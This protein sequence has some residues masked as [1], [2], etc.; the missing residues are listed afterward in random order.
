MGKGY[1]VK[2]GIMASKGQF[3]IFIDAD[4]SIDPEE[5]KKM[6]KNL[7][8]FDAVVGTRASNKSVVKKQPLIRKALG[9]IF[10]TYVNA[11][12]GICVKD[13]LCGFKGFKYNV[14]MKIFRNLKSNRW[15]F[16]VEIFYKIRKNKYTLYQ[17]PIHWVHKENTKIK[18]LDPLKMFLDVL[19]LRLKLIRIVQNSN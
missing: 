5:I 2:T 12:F 19:I 3:V 7:I 1:A 15:V 10:N 9:I 8:G 17:T 6:G 4:G 13:T 16:D 18:R 14:A 11:V